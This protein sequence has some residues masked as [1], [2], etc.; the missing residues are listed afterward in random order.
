MV[1]AEAATAFADRTVLAARAAQFL[2]VRLRDRKVG[3]AP[4]DH[5]ATGEVLFDRCLEQL[6]GVIQL[7]R[8]QEFTIGKLRQ[9]FLAA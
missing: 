7:P 2:V 9:V 1:R 3:V 8:G 5:L 4:D 6:F